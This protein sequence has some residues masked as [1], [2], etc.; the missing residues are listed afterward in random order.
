MQTLENFITPNPKSQR[1]FRNIKDFP[2]LNEFFHPKPN[3][4]VS[5]PHPPY[6]GAP[7]SSFG[8]IKLPPRN[9]TKQLP[10]LSAESRFS[11]FHQQ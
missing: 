10:A 7:L 3:H 4:I 2:L 1:F 11:K 9:T 8:T 6:T 5:Y